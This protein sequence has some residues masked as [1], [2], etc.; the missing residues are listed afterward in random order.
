MFG[1]ELVSSPINTCVSSYEKY[2]NPGATGAYDPTCQPPPSDWI[3]ATAVVCRS[4]IACTS[5]RR[6]FSAVACAVMTSVKLT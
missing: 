5:A 2:S 1:I 3:N 4:A 6:A